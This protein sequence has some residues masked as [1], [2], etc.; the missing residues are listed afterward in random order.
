M[1]RQHDILAHEAVIARRPLDRADSY[2]VL[3]PTG[4]FAW[5]SDPAQATPFA[6]MRE[7]A[8]MALRLP[9]ELKAYGLPRKVELDPAT[10][11]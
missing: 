6:S 5:T 8:R 4:R 7:A 1:I 10:L 3:Y 2:L 9:A 11:H